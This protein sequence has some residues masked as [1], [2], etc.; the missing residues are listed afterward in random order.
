MGSMYGTTIIKP[1]ETD[2]I[3]TYSR[4]YLEKYIPLNYIYIDSVLEVNGRH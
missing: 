2:T 3:I 1:V 4:V